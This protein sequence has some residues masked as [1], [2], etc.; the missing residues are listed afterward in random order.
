[1]R[2]RRATGMTAMVELMRVSRLNSPLLSVI[3][4]GRLRM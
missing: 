1:M 2:L 3:A 4:G